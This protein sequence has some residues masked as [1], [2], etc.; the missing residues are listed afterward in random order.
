MQTQEHAHRI[1]AAEHPLWFGQT[2]GGWGDVVR[3]ID[4]SE[5]HDT[6]RMIEAASTSS[7]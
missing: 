2:P 1:D 4:P 3:T 5:A 7:T 6:A